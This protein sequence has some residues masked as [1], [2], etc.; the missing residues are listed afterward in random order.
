MTPRPDPTIVARG[1]PPA[2][3]DVWPPLCGCGGLCD[4]GAACPLWPL[5]TRLGGAA[6]Q[7]S[8]E[9]SQPGHGRGDGFPVPRG[10]RDVR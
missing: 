1:N 8:A 2:H 7:T 10:T 6:A 5:D 3:P 9:S 4:A